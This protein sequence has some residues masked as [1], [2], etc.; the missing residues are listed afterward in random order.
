MTNRKLHSQCNICT[1][2]DNHVA[3]VSVIPGT[4]R[5]GYTQKTSLPTPQNSNDET[6]V[7]GEK[8]P[9]STHKSPS[10]S[11]KQ[12]KVIK[13]LEHLNIFLNAQIN[14]QHQLLF[15]TKVI[16]LLTPKNQWQKI[17][18]LLI[19]HH[20]HLPHKNKV[21]N[22]M[23]HLNMI[24]NTQMNHQ[25]PLLSKIKVIHIL[26]QKMLLLIMMKY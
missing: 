5:I 11:T 23:E 14:H 20:V 21:I 18:N 6:S 26:T 7:T 9:Q 12:K 4:N 17:P 15:K 3:K 2:T 16:K 19:I 25:H 8:N 13:L 24:L 10:L 22:L 1:N